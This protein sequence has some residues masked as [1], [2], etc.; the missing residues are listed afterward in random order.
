MD[1]FC[2]KWKRSKWKAV[3]FTQDVLRLLSKPISRKNG[4]LLTTECKWREIGRLRR[5]LLG[6]FCLTWIFF[7][8]ILCSAEVERGRTKKHTQRR[9]RKN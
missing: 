4:A 3:P 9:R 5:A 6:L 2:E 1:D 8:E 7:R